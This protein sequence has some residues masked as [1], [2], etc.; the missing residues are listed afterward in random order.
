MI[1]PNMFYEM[2][3]EREFKDISLECKKEDYLNYHFRH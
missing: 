3:Y 1:K 2:L